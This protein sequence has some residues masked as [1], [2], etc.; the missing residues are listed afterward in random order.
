[1]GNLFVFIIGWFESPTPLKERR[2]KTLWGLL[3][4]GPE[5][6]VEVHVQ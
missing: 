1:M 2:Q 5:E 3:S 4:A 6:S